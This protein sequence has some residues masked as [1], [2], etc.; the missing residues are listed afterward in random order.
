MTDSTEE[1]RL[2]KR[3]RQEC[4]GALD[5]A[6]R[7]AT[8][9]AV[10]EFLRKTRAWKETVAFEVTT[11]S[12]EYE[13]DTES[14]GAVILGVERVLN[15]EDIP[16]TGWGMF[17]PPILRIR[18]YPDSTYTYSAELVLGI[19][20][21]TT[22][23]GWPRLPDW[24]WDRYGYTVSEGTIGI[25]QS[26]PLK[27]YTSERLA[28]YHLRRFRDKTAQVAHEASRRYVDGGQRWR[29]PRAFA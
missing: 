10:D 17:E 7:F 20:D 13:L 1:L 12:N 3:V 28:I 26:Q 21:P 8:F 6:I 5:D 9:Q 23:E 27:P 14:N 15:E 29:F 16:L 18:N 24:L 22:S 25:L 2:L 11:G 19:L 4:P